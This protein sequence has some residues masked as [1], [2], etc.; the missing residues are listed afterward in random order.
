MVYLDWASTALPDPE[1]RDE[2]YKAAAEHYANPSSVHEAGRNARSLLEESR[3]RWARALG[4]SPG[5]V[6]FTSGG[7]ESNNLILQQL[8]MKKRKP[9]IVLSAAE[10]PSLY[11]SALKLKHSGF[12][13]RFVFPGRDGHIVPAEFTEAVDGTTGFAALMA[14]NNV[15][16]AV[17]PVK[18][19]VRLIRDKTEGGRKVHFHTDAVQAIGK[20]A[21]KLEELDVDSASFSAHKFR[22]PRG[23]GVLYLRGEIPLLAAGGDQE[24]GLRPGTENLYAVYG[25]AL[26]VQKAVG[27]LEANYSSASKLMEKITGTLGKL[28]EVTLL[29]DRWNSSY[30]PYVTTL[31]VPPVPGEVLVRTFSDRGFMV[32]TGSAC[33]TRRSKQTRVYNNMG[34]PDRLAECS[35][36]ISIGESTTEEE[37]DRFISHFRD[38]VKP[39]VK[40]AS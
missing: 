4:C 12:D 2:A 29:Y 11:D 22:A 24:M 16:G 13:V 6:V 15:T 38:T 18:E 35:L 39:L 10:H 32:G 28:P 26:G 33:S 21:L 37:V 9:S 36:R 30:S 25:S 3:K 40:I 1:I 34:L 19:T 8:L 27:G 31:F 7:T 17:Q 14:V 23:C 20:I 5:Q